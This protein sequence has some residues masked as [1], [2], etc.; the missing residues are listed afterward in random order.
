M[1]RMNMKFLSI[2]LAS[3]L[4][5]SGCAKETIQT[6]ADEVESAEKKFYPLKK[7]RVFNAAVDAFLRQL[8]RGMQM[9]S[10]RCFPRMH[11]SRQRILTRR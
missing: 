9:R 7:D 4:L 2:L 8:T 3:V 1:K 11:W 5:L 10:R 6:Q